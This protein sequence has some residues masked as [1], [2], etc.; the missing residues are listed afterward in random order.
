MLQYVFVSI[1]L[2]KYGENIDR[3][4]YFV[5][6][7]RPPTVTKGLIFC[8]KELGREPTILNINCGVCVG[9]GIECEIMGKLLH[10]EH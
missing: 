1:Y 7:P 2:L 9:G 5:L 10:L 4:L 3:F 8:K 6:S